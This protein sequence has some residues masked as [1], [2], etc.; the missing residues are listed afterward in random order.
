MRAVSILLL[1]A[2]AAACSRAPRLVEFRDPAGRYSLEVPSSWARDLDPDPDRKPA[3]T[4]R[5]IGALEPQREGV[6]L[7]AVLEVTQLSRR[8]DAVPGGPAAFKAFDE[9]VLKPTRDL[10]GDDGASAATRTYSRSYDYGGPTPFHPEPAVSMSAQGAVYRTADAYYVVEYRAT[11]ENF[12]K[13]RYA[14]DR[15]LATF[16]VAEAAR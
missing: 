10:F 6:P 4:A 15:A 5:F 11:R 1:L 16:R 14:L 9:K 12:D 8:P 2:A 7:G 3:T 13:C